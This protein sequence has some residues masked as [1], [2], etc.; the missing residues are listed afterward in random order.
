MYLHDVNQQNSKYGPTCAPLLKIISPLSFTMFGFKTG[1]TSLRLRSL[2]QLQIFKAYDNIEEWLYFNNYDRSK[3]SDI[4][5]IIRFVYGDESIDANIY[6]KKQ[7]P[8]HYTLY[9]WILL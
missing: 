1:V 4:D 9:C 5:S 3:C 8:T 6:I 7:I 2:D